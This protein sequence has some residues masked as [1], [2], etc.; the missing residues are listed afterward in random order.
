MIHEKFLSR[1]FVLK[2]IKWDDFIG[3]RAGGF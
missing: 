2:M 1:K 3:P